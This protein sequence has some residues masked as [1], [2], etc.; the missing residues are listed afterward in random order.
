MI[1]L[2]CWF[3]ACGSPECFC[4]VDHETT[5]FVSFIFSVIHSV[6]S[7]LFICFSSLFLSNG[8]F[9][10]VSATFSHSSLSL[11]LL[12]STLFYSHLIPVFL[13]LLF[14]RLFISLFVFL[15]ICLFRHHFTMF[16][17]LFL[18]A[19]LTV[20]P[21]LILSAPVVPWHDPDEREHSSLC[22]HA[23]LYVIRAL[24]C[25]GLTR[26]KHN[27]DP[28]SPAFGIPESAMKILAQK[29]DFR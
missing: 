16:L 18:G 4:F 11:I 10:S 21:P 27:S 26:N 3:V 13:S 29:Q 8:L 14:L 20:S 7:P 15:F 6:F 28:Y 17:S 22:V 1:L 5:L 25:Y 19:F 2:V 24:V 12:L 9:V 23:V